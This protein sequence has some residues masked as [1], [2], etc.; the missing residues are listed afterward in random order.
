MSDF[1]KQFINDKYKQIDIW[2]ES[3]KSKIVLAYDESD[4]QVYVIK[5]LKNKDVPYQELKK[6]DDRILPRIYYIFDGD[7]EIILVEEYICGITLNELIEQKKYISDEEIQDILVQLC[8]G[9]KNLHQ[10]DIIHRDIN[11]NNIMLTNDGVVKLVD[12]DTVRIFKYDQNF[13]TTYLGTKGFAPPEQYGFSQTD[14]RT[15]I[16]ALG[17]TIKKLQPKSN[18][19]QKIITKATQL[20]PENRYQYV[21]EILNEIEDEYKFEQKQNKLTLKQIEIMLNDKFNLFEIPMPV[22]EKDYPFDF[23]KIPF[24][25]P[26]SMVDDLDYESVEEAQKAM[27]E[28][29][30]NN[31]FSLMKEYIKD[32]LETYKIYQLKKYY[33]YYENEQ[34]YYFKVNKEIE[35]IINLMVKRFKLDLPEYLK[36]FNYVPS[37]TRFS[38]KQD[39]Q[40]YHLWQLKHLEETNYVEEIKREFIDRTLAY[41]AERFFIYVTQYLKKDINL[42][43]LTIVDDKTNEEKKVYHF[44]FDTLSQCFFDELM[45]STDFIIKDNPFLQEDVE[46]V[47]IKYYLPE[48]KEVLKAKTNEIMT[49]L[50]EYN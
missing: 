38:G 7:E 42:E 27:I 23:N 17:M 46:G 40:M 34:N 8:K 49:F 9:L 2:K 25:T 21:E 31:V 39:E 12:F 48:L 26:I 13:D 5:Y 3:D 36:H 29:F 45:K 37:F 19:L 20:D 18:L 24:Y 47:L 28:D 41:D 35:R 1:V 16:Y 30:E 43:E 15:D 32:I 14:A 6:I 50:K 10:R 22:Q 33:M 44:N 11:L 4:R